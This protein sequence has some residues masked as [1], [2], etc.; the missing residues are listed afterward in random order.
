VIPGDQAD[1][2]R[3]RPAQHVRIV[4]LTAPVFRALAH[5][6]LAAAN[7]VSPVPLS[8]WDDK[9]GLEV[10]YEVDAGLSR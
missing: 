1:S 10:I 7:A 5:G 2:P 3:R 4:Q 9:D 8:Q 6:D